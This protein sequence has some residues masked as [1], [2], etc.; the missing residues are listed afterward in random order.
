[1]GKKCRRRT[2]VAIGDMHLPWVSRRVL[3]IILRNVAL[4]KP[5]IVIQMGDLFDMFSWSRFPR[6]H[7]LMTPAQEF[8]KARKMAVQFWQAVAKACPTAKRI[9]LYGN[10]DERPVKQI[11]AK[12]PEYE[13]FVMDHLKRSF[14]FEDVETQKNAATEIIIDD[15]MYIHG[16]RSKLGDHLDSSGGLNVVRAHSHK[17]GT[18]TKVHGDLMGNRYRLITELDC[19]FVADHRAV[20]LSY[21]QQRRFNNFTHGFGLIDPYGLRFVPIG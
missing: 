9:Q 5:D 1:M 7:G 20:P 10:H 4:I 15:C 17:G 21:S 16:Y 11:L 19:G 12:A 14:T 13:L 6:T 2:V 18:V 8:G 3:S